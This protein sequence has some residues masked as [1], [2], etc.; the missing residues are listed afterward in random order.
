M[1]GLPEAAPAWS[2]PL[3][4]LSISEAS[5]LSLAVSHQGALERVITNGGC[6]RA[7]MI[8]MNERHEDV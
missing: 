5:R 2:T 4:F 3:P 7:I 6:G 8:S 1:S